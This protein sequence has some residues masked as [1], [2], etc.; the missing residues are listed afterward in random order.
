MLPH[1]LMCW[2]SDVTLPRVL[3]IKLRD[4]ILN[5]V[6]LTDVSSARDLSVSC[7]ANLLRAACY[8]LLYPIHIFCVPMHGFM[9]LT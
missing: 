7:D 5:C 8:M 6:I 4:K 9:N 2:P 3:N 1:I